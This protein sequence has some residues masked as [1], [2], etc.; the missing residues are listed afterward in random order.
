MKFNICIAIPIKSSDFD[1]NEIL[2]KNVLK[3]KPDFIE[4]RFDYIDD[5]QK[6]TDEFVNKLL[7][8]LQ[9][10]ISVIFTLRDF[11]E[12]GQINLSNE[13]RL[14]ILKILIKAQPKYLDIEMNSAKS[15]LEKIIFLADQNN[16][17]LI[18]SYHN[19]KET[20]T[21][22]EGFNII[23]SFMNK[24]VTKLIIDSKIVRQSIYKAIFTA[25]NIE[26][27]LIPLALCKNF[28]KQGHKIISFCMGDSGIFSRLLCV[29]VGSFLTYASLGD[30]TAPGQVNIRKMKKFYEILF[31]RS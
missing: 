17:N 30:K 15:I 31:N 6:I 20:T 8:L 26:D 14:R 27:N 11:S 10:N 21:Y 16:V 24:L 4:L 1:Q 23:E 19:F 29:K 13:E 22:E 3:E 12:G 28:S 9:P 2:I 25:Q 7:K 18:F 5:I